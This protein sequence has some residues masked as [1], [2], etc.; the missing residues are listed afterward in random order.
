[1]KKILIYIFLLS[2]SFIP[3][4]IGNTQNPFT[5]KP[6]NQHMTPEPLIKSKFF[7]KII[8]WQQQLR[9]KMSKLI[10]QVDT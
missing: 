8:F 4:S 1:M 2:F 5:S 7:V 9:E 6:E 3:V 10:R